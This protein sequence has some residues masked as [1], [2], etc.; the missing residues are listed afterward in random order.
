MAVI[1]STFEDDSTMKIKQ[2]R[3]RLEEF[4]K[5]VRYVIR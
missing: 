2:W 4:P 3:R 1:R 5:E